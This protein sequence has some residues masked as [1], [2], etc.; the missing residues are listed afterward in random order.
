MEESRGKDLDN[1]LSNPRRALIS[2]SIPLF[3]S[4]LVANLQNFI[5]GVWCSGL[6]SDELS[7]ISI[8]APIYMLI[9]AVGSGIGIG[10]SAAV[11]RYLGAGDKGMADRVAST[12]IVLMAIISVC[13]SLVMY[14]LAEPLI[15]FCG[16]GN[17]VGM[18]MEYTAPFLWCSFF[19]M[20][21]GVLA[22]LFR[23]EGASR[24]SM[25]LSVTA[26]LINIVLDPIMIYG[27][28]LGVLGASIATCVSFIAIT[29]IG[30][31]M[32]ARGRMYVTISPRLVM[33]R[34]PV[35]YDIAVV[36]VPCAIELVLSPL[37]IIPEQALVVSCGG[38]DGL[39]VYVNAF[40]FVSL[41]LIPAS[42]ISKS[43]I[44]IISAAIGQR[45]VDKISECIRLTYKIVFLMEAAS[46]V[47][48]FVA[49]DLLVEILMNSESMEALR[50]E[51]VLATRIYSI[52]C[53]F[54]SLQGVGMSIMQ[55]T[56]HAFTATLM[57][58]MREFIFLGSYFV[59]SRIS[60]T[61][62]YWSLDL[63]NLI[64]V[65]VISAVAVFTLKKV[66]AELGQPSK[67]WIRASRRPIPPRSTQNTGQ[68]AEIGL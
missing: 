1:L 29:V 38:S 49:A 37:L 39:V 44:P 59:A 22:G 57:T 32:Y 62:I 63:T 10:A 55:A 23:A 19:L 20:M 54:N 8:S 48:L 67:S 7:A 21:N 15:R 17:N 36:G 68:A 31:M 42:A 34:N 65:C 33:L 12:T 50:D 45:D 16:G 25:V 14:V 66:Y 3:F 60:M 47:F 46:A 64:V 13:S 24:K 26:S 53:I 52:T 27:L 35:L 5:D 40:R 6:G 30:L 9:T 56:K 11:A 61:A 41:V 51:L 58:F 4:M 2:M 43:L 28:G 18:C